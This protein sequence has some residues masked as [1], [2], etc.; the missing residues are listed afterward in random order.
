MPALVLVRDF[1]RDAAAA[2]G[3]K[4][5][6]PAKSSQIANVFADFLSRQNVKVALGGYKMFRLQNL[7]RPLRNDVLPFVRQPPLATRTP[8]D[9]ATVEERFDGSA[10]S[11][12]A[13]DFLLSANGHV[14]DLCAVVQRPK[15]AYDGLLPKVTVGEEF[16]LLLF[17]L[18]ACHISLANQR[19]DGG[20]GHGVWK[21]NFTT[22]YS[23]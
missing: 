2:Y 10:V 18:G 21:C 9:A 1:G 19:P 12:R 15:F 4:T 3:S 13:E 23:S 11:A 6:R 20:G 5:F 16:L 14:R 17:A 7:P 8:F 22:V